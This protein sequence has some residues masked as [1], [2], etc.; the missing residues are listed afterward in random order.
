MTRVYPNAANAFASSVSS[1]AV[2]N[3]VADH[4]NSPVVLTIWKKS[5][6]F[7]CNV[8]TLFDDQGNLVFRV[9]NYN[10]GTKEECLWQFSSH[11]PPKEAKPFGQLVNIQWR[12]D[13]NPSVV[14]SEEERQPS[15]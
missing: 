1:A 13:N 2:P 9:D 5:L 10:T 12:D 7:N 15:L 4:G 11:H 6:L 3:S 8:F 14:F